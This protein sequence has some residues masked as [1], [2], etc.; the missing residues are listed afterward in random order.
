MATIS[1]YFPNRTADMLK[2]RFHSS[3][4]RKYDLEELKALESSRR[5]SLAS[6]ITQEMT[7][8]EMENEGKAVEKTEEIEMGQNETYSPY[9]VS[10]AYNY[11]DQ[12][13]DNDI[14][15]NEVMKTTE[16]KNY[17]EGEMNFHFEDYFTI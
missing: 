8:I 11:S 1:N 3:L 16:R 9:F 17:M 6:V 13:Q 12:S 10:E 7:V 15:Y 4:K 5:G 2:N 14:F